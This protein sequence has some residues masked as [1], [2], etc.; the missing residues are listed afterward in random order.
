MLEIF[1]PTKI[2]NYSEINIVSD[3]FINVL[4]NNFENISINNFSSTFFE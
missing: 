4:K 3:N 2:K 1:I